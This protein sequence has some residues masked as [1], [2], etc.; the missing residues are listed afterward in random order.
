MFTSASRSP[1][2]PRPLRLPSVL[3]QN[4]DASRQFALK[5]SKEMPEAQR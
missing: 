4:K 3:S 5:E 2:P 1:S